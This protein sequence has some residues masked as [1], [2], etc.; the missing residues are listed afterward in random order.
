MIVQGTS[1]RDLLLGTSSGDTIYGYGEDDQLEGLAG[2]DLLNGGAGADTL[3]GGSGIDLLYGGAGDDLLSDAQAAGDLLNGEAGND[4]LTVGELYWAVSSAT[5]LGGIGNDT[6]VASAGSFVL[7]G[8]D[9]NDMFYVSSAVGN[10]WSVNTYATVDGGSGNDTIIGGRLQDIVFRGDLG[11]DLVDLSTSS[12][13]I[14]CDAGDDTVRLEK[15]EI[16]RTL[17][18]ETLNISGGIGRDTITVSGRF[19]VSDGTTDVLLYGGDGDDLLSVEPE[20][21]SGSSYGIA[22]AY[23]EGGTGSD[24]LRCY[25]AVQVTFT[26]GLNSDIFELSAAQYDTQLAGERIYSASTGYVTV[27]PRPVVITDFQAGFGGDILDLGSLLNLLATGMTGP[28]PFYHGHIKFVQSNT[29]TIVK[30]DADGDTGPKSDVDVAILKKVNSNLI[31]FDNLKLG[32]NTAPQV[33]G[34]FRYTFT[35]TANDDVFSSV[36]GTVLTS[37]PDNN[38]IT[39]IL[40]FAHV[41]GDT[42]TVDGQFGRFTLNLQSGDYNYSPYD[43]AME[44]APGS[45]YE[46]FNI[47]VSDGVLTSS[48][49]VEVRVDGANDTPTGTLT[50][51]GTPLVGQSLSVLNTVQDRDGMMNGFEYQWYADGEPIIE[52]I[53]DTLLLGPELIGRSISVTLSYYDGFLTFETVEGSG[54]VVVTSPNDFYGDPG[55]VVANDTLTGNA[56][57]NGMFGLGG[58]DTLYGLGGHDTIECGSSNDFAY[59]GDGDDLMSGGS[60]DD[61]LEGQNGNDML[62]GGDGNDTLTGLTGNDVMLGGAG[63]DVFYSFVGQGPDTIYGGIGTDTLTISRSNLAIA[64]TLNIANPEVLQTMADGTTIIGI[65]QINYRGSTGNDSVIGGGLNDTLIGNLGNDSLYGGWGLDSLSGEAGN[66]LLSGGGQNDIL[67]GGGGNDTLDGGGGSDVMRGGTGNDTYIV[68]SAT[69]TTEDTGG[70]DI[71]LTSVTYTIGANIENVTITSAASLARSATGNALANIITGS[72]GINVL[73]GLDGN[74]RI[75]GKA[76]ADKLLGGNGD[77]TLSGGLGYDELTGSAGNDRFVFASDTEIGGGGT[78]LPS[79]LIRD[80]VQGQDRI[81]LSAIDAKTSTPLINEA[82]SFIGAAAFTAAGQV[83]AFTN[84][85]TN[86]TLIQGDLDGDKVADF[87]LQLVGLK[88]LAGADFVL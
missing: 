63:N 76:G 39:M 47:D 73:S 10:S 2:S 78:L 55:G 12:A 26:G 87:Q 30:F 60:G 8:Q 65:E 16:N 32:E 50:I 74:D 22:R 33:N 51:V 44:A 3:Y 7:H 36:K 71:V 24:V 18:A 9:D 11:N 80:F 58:N 17:A 69:D 4:Y 56:N 54:T 35:D 82:F 62:D 70:I 86:R 37:D 6:L 29:D 52:G 59:G 64:L 45:I 19:F 72:D 41:D 79:D 31:T 25:G 46:T 81:D 68:D 38:P 34:P 83:R 1:G 21:W 49:F 53:H 43:G 85:A 27:Q 88:T 14:A 61:W 23:L 48:T 15:T 57:A 75:Y 42:A 66:D 40:W 20:Q 67:D 28:N 84:V 77:D 13:A 5:L